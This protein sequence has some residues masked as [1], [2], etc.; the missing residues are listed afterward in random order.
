MTTVKVEIFDPPMCCSTGICGPTVD[1]DLLRINEA[2]LALEKAHPLEV[3]IKRYLP[4]THP[5]A[6]LGNQEVTRLMR[7]NGV[8]VLPITVVNGDVVRTGA[9]PTYAELEAEVSA[10]LK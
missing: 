6:F 3:E 7:D 2:L 9:Y 10:R 5:A 1:P 8:E 4:T